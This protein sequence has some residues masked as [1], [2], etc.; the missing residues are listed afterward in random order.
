MVLVGTP[1]PAGCD[2]TC[3]LCRENPIDGVLDL[4]YAVDAYDNGALIEV[5]LV[6]GGAELPVTDAN[7]ADYVRCGLI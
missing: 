4:T 7:K 2:N 5:E 1:D 6:P 3:R